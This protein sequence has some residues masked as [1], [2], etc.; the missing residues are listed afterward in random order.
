MEA[1]GTCK[2]RAQRKIVK[3]KKSKKKFQTSMESSGS[4]YAK[5]SFPAKKRVHVPQ[6]LLSETPL[7]NLKLGDSVGEISQEKEGTENVSVMESERPLQSEKQDC[8]LSPFFWLREEKD[9]DKLSQPTDD[10][11]VIEGLTPIPPSFS[12]LKDSD[13][14]NTSN[15][16][17]LVSTGLTNN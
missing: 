14:E 5:P 7:K 8:V 3:K 15:D 12:D 16:A 13:D 17:P 4:D 10:D 1:G 2:G 11:Q 9:G 6:N